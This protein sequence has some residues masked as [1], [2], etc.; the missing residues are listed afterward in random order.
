MVHMAIFSAA[1][2]NQTRDIMGTVL[3]PEPADV[4]R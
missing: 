1:L 4:S 2:A 3:A